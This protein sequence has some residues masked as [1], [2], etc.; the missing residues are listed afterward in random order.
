M[1]SL[2]PPLSPRT[3]KEYEPSGSMTSMS[4][5]ERDHYRASDDEGMGTMNYS[6]SGSMTSMSY[7]DHYRASEDA[8]NTSGTMMNNSANNNNSIIESNF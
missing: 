2:L 3:M 8:M 7:R 4:Y 5:R 6:A 1:D